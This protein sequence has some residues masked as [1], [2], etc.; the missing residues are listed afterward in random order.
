VVLLVVA[1]PVIAA[2]RDA[3][4]PSRELVAASVTDGATAIRLDGEL[5]DAVWKA[6]P[7]VTAFVQ[8]EPQEGAPATFRT[9]ARVAYDSTGIYVAVRAYDPEP[10]RIV[11]FLTRRD[12]RSSS[13]WIRVLID[14]YHDRR[15]AY[16]FA[17]NPLGVKQDTYWFNDGNFDE[18]WDAVWDVVVNR[19]DEGWRAEFHIPFSQLR[20]SRHSDGRLG[21]AVVREIARLSEIS[22]WPL[23]AKSASGYV[24]S[25]GEL[26]GVA[27]AAI[28]SK[29]L[30][31]VPYTVAQ[32]ATVPREEGNPLQNTVDPGASLGFDTKYRVTPALTL[33]ATVN[34]DFGQVEADPAVV[35]LTAF[36]T[37][38]AERRPFFVEG[39]GTYRF[40]IDCS[41][42]QCTGLFY[43]RRI[44]RQPRG[45]PE[46]PDEG[47]FAVTPLQS[48]IIGAGKLTGRV[49]KFS[50]GALTAATQ[51]ERARVSIDGVQHSEVVEPLTFYT[52]A[53]ARREFTNQSSLGFMI[54]STNR[55]I[56]PDVNFLPARA[57]T[58]G[59]D[60]DWR[61]GR[62]W[63]LSGYWAGSTVHGSTEAIT[64]LQE[65]NVHSFQ[66]PD[67]DHIEEDPQATALNG[68]AGMISFSKIAGERV[69][70]N[71]N[72]SYKSPG[73]E[74]NDVGYLQR[75]DERTESNWLQW[76]FDRPGSH[77][78]T[79]R[80]N[81]NQWAGWNFGGDRLFSG[82]NVNA[83]WTF[84]N[85]WETGTGF[86]MN[87]RGFDDRR[88]RG[89]PGAYIN[90]RIGHWFYLDTDTR[91]VASFHWVSFWNNDS[92][93]SRLIDANPR[94]VLRPASA[95]SAEF[96]IRWTSNE[97]DA[98]WI[99]DAEDL[100][101]AH[102]VFGRLNQTTVGI[103]TRLNYT[104]RPNLSVQLYGEPFVSAG[105][106]ENYK[107]LVNGRAE[108]YADRYA[109]FAY[110]GNA[111]FNFLSF[112]TTNVMRWEFKPG[113]TLFIVWQQSREQD[114]ERGDFEFGRDFREVFSIPSSNTF[115]VKLAYWFNM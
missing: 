87:W 77:V 11:G 40:D 78:R 105:H 88:T 70:L 42:G 41:D 65:D 2:T 109:P 43:S 50:I 101:P 6:A 20:F 45:E 3:A 75:A 92:H 84:T 97:D 71:S 115:L 79:F 91:K 62:R 12:V 73:F 56:A 104:I 85:F 74:I 82:G 34:P 23:L 68:H 83:H 93:G 4:D 26:T 58:G 46:L 96:G 33:T 48:T 112:R 28:T 53:R 25:F 37:F 95:L 57:I 89:G 110:D 108:R 55:D 111:D 36:E 66:R 72:F 86:N 60:Y 49:G 59:V 114:G 29:R 27:P 18:S 94:V 30:E 102:Y 52:V 63:G 16:E 31:L 38:F 100:A 113:S 15:T 61:I 107:E 39:S 106:Y 99:E 7:A 44:G 8:R 81:F 9:E 67:A 103:T 51:E 13:D 10:K 76:R 64:D 98:Q 32:V 1:A 21:F 80:I 5:D 35:N 90:G 14:S 22:T 47:G 19:D 54:T 17:V 69:R 24:S